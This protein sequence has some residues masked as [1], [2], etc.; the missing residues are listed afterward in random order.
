[1]YTSAK[2]DSRSETAD[3][4]NQREAVSDTRETRDRAG[5]GP[6]GV[7]RSTDAGCHAVGMLFGTLA[8]SSVARSGRRDNNSRVGRCGRRQK[9]TTPD[10]VPLTPK[11]TCRAG[12]APHAGTHSFSHR[13]AA[14]RLC[15]LLHGWQPRRREAGWHSCARLVAGVNAWDER[16]AEG[17]ALLLRVRG[18]LRCPPP[19]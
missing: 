19:E 7:L 12:P 3:Q 6:P 1:M 2:L 4:Q 18:R 17:Q 8:A 5:V 16:R 14:P 13:A 11:D 10:L 15:R 9:S